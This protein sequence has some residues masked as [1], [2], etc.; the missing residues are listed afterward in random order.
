MKSKRA[1]CTPE[2]KDHIIRRERMIADYNKAHNADITLARR[3]VSSVPCVIIEKKTNSQQTRSTWWENVRILLLSPILKSYLSQSGDLAVWR[4]PDP[5]RTVCPLLL[6]FVMTC[7]LF[8]EAAFHCAAAQWKA[9]LQ[10]KDKKQI[11]RDWISGGNDES[12]RACLPAT[13][14]GSSQNLI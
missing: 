4:R 14:F 1:E 5:I 7:F 8:R 12:R 6:R 9:A 3:T 2:S 10:N 11:V 13:S